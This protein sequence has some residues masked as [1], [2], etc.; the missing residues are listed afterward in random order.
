MKWTL[1]PILAL[2]LSVSLAACGGGSKEQDAVEKAAL[3]ITAAL[4]END[5]EGFLAGVTDDFLSVAFSPVPSRD[6]LR[7]GGLRPTGEPAGELSDFR[8]FEISDESATVEVLERSAQS[9]ERLRLSLVKRGD[10]WLLDGMEVLKADAPDGAT[11]VAL[12]AVDNLF[13]FEDERAS[14]PAGHLVFQLTNRGNQPHNMF[15]HK[16]AEGVSV[17]QAYE[18]QM[19][20]DIGAP[21]VGLLSNVDGGAEATWTLE[22][23]E[24]GRYGYY[25]WVADLR[26]ITPHAFLGMAGEFTVE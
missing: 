10:A 6:D 19:P 11:E 2:A 23:L 22:D 4:N 1:L 26:T 24:P 13:T 20:T 8:N 3:G 7:A 21:Y 25:C 16:L 5:V 18:A 14:F 12:E 9:V 17:R 15:V